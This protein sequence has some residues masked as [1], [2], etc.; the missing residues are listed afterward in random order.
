[1]MSQLNNQ[2][3]RLLQI[4]E[5]NITA[6]QQQS[7]KEVLSQIQTQKLSQI[8]RLLGTALKQPKSRRQAALQRVFKEIAQLATLHKTPSPKLLS[9]MK[10]ATTNR[11]LNQN[12]LIA[13][14]AG[15]R[16]ITDTTELEAKAVARQRKDMNFYWAKESRRFRDDVAASVRHGIRRGLDQEELADLIQQRTGVHRSRAVLIA[17][18][19]ILTAASRAEIDLLK[20]S[21]FGRYLWQT[22]LDTKVRSEH[23]VRQGR[24][25]T[26]RGSDILPG[27]AIKCRCRAIP[28]VIARE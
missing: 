23:A 11:V 8:E 4:E 7:R 1:M 15:G 6:I 25:Y 13:L 20:A 10:R 26:W 27:Q 5:R 17:D 19:Q 12:D 22:R 9:L 16:A 18:D 3:R 21:G 24:I 28:A 2:I 14:L